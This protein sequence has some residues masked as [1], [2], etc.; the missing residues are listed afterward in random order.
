[1]R[2]S[3]PLSLSFPAVF[4]HDQTLPLPRPGEVPSERADLLSQLR[5]DGESPSENR[6]VLKPPEKDGHRNHHNQQNKQSG[7]MLPFSLKLYYK[8]I[9]TQEIKSY[10]VTHTWKL[11]LLWEPGNT[12][13][14]Q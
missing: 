14:V 12:Q 6:F 13:T 9:K 2:N 4:P 5:T 3:G 8:N 10:F 11:W 7:I 1:M